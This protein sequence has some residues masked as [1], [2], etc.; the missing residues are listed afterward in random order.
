MSTRDEIIQR[1][2]KIVPGQDRGKLYKPDLAYL[3]QNST[4]SFASRLAA[5]APS[6]KEST[7]GA[8]AA[9]LPSQ[10]PR[11]TKAEKQAAKE[12][13]RRI[14]EATAQR[15]E[16]R[17]AREVVQAQRA[18][19]E[20]Y[21]KPR[22]SGA[23]PTENQW[24]VYGDLQAGQPSQSGQRGQKLQRSR[25]GPVS[26]GGRGGMK[27]PTSHSRGPVRPQV[28][29]IRKTPTTEIDESLSNEDITLSVLEDGG[30][31]KAPAEFRNP[32]IP[33][34]NLDDLFG[35]S[36]AERVEKAA[37][38][39]SEDRIEWLRETYGGDYIRFAPP[40]A[41]NF[42]TEPRTLGPLKHAQFVLSKRGDVTVGSRKDALAIITSAIGAS[43]S[44]GIQRA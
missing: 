19:E 13:E 36:A 31:D 43:A 6:V 12:R 2:R 39:P 24:G 32:D 33:F 9:S 27:R 17:L 37:R 28:A 14:A 8:Q 3:K 18:A 40:A 15:K 23:K 26:R 7:P 35:P 11:P 1:P 20:S 34:T 44:R 41:A 5:E 29:L 10:S 16:Q 21:K 22:Q 42:G 38:S 30:D 25:G 4:S